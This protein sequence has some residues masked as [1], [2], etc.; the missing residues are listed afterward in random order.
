MLTRAGFLFGAL[1][2]G[3]AR[4]GPYCSPL[5]TD[6]AGPPYDF[7]LE[8][9]DGNGQ[10]FRLAQ[11]LGSAVWLN[12]FASWCPS[13]DGEADRLA[14]LAAHYAPHGLVTVGIDYKEPPA[15]V[16]AFRDRH[17]ITF[18]IA[19]DSMGSVFAGLGLSALPTHLFFDRAGRITC[20][21]ADDISFKAMDNEI[22]VALGA[23]SIP[24]AAP[25]L[26]SP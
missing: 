8:L 3:G 21:A 15:P 5:A 11:Q 12:F 1:A 4:P 25:P 16:R 7:E 24:I 20:V 23:P 10:T 17:K 13:C 19:L 26:Q 6:V 2:T 9:L 14:R 18:P 22:S